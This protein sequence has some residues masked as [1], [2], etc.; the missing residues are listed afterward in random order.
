MRKSA[1][2]TVVPRERDWIPYLALEARYGYCAGFQVQGPPLIG[3]KPISDRAG[4]FHVTCRV[5][6][7]GQHLDIPRVQMRYFM[8]WGW[9]RAS[10]GLWYKFH[11]RTFMNM[12]KDIPKAP[13]FH[14][15]DNIVCVDERTG[16]VRIT[17]E[18]EFSCYRI[19]DIENL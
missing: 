14:D 15:A 17:P 18:Q 4:K 16:L 2:G 11:L 9:R 12:R 8:A 5:D 7:D 1:A 10:S 19:E 6:Q 13:W 3:I